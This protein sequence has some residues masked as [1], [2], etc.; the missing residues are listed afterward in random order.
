MQ[1]IKFR[2]EHSIR[3]DS[4]PIDQ[5]T[6][7]ALLA[8]FQELFGRPLRQHEILRYLD[9]QSE[10]I[11]ISSDREL[12]EAIRLNNHGTLEIMSLDRD[13]IPH[14]TDTREHL[15]NKDKRSNWRKPFDHHPSRREEVHR[16][17]ESTAK[18]SEH[19]SHDRRFH[20]PFRHPASCNNCSAKIVGDRHK[21]NDCLDYN[22]CD[23]CID[24]DVHPGHT[25]TTLARSYRRWHH[26]RPSRVESTQ[27]V[28]NDTAASPSP[29]VNPSPHNSTPH[30]HNNQHTEQTERTH[31][32]V[33]D[34]TLKTQE[35]SLEQER[36]ATHTSEGIT[37]QQQCHNTSVSTLTNSG[38]NASMIIGAL[39]TLAAEGFRDKAKNVGLLMTFGGNVEQVREKL[40][41][42]QLEEL[43]LLVC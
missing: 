30:T 26:H 32:Q 25:F 35:P 22:L 4:L 29:H 15:I 17:E 31:N 13:M 6:F 21:C 2:A 10:W 37:S 11:D 14:N 19:S 27:H 9:D 7:S 16:F 33:E 38:L 1:A 20:G 12:R 34:G 41:D 36:A 8:A 39:Q 5:L 28:V 24:N 43:G 18:P 23:A 40:V 42:E 3:R